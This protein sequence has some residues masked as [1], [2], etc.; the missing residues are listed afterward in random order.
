MTTDKDGQKSTDD[1]F[2]VSVTH[3]IDSYKHCQAVSEN[4]KR[5]KIQL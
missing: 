4:S 3:C 2:K 5:L 1:S